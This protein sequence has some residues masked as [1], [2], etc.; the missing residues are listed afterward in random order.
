MKK[1]YLIT[2]ASGL[3]GQYLVPC[4]AQKGHDIV[5]IMNSHALSS[6]IANVEQLRADL[7]Q[8]ADVEN[9]LDQVAPEVIIHA[10]GMTN[11]DA[12]ERESQKAHLINATLPSWIAQWAQINNKAFVFISTDHI[13]DGK[14]PYFDEKISPAPLN[15]YAQTKVEAESLI[16]AHM[17]GALLLRTNF[18]GKGPHWRQSIT[19]WIWGNVGA[20]RSIPG[21]TDSYFSPI[22]GPELSR[23]MLM[24]IERGA[25]GIFH[26]G[27]RER[28]SKFDFAR[29]FTAM[30]GYDEALI[31]PALM[32]DAPLTAPRPMDMSM[33]VK[34][35]EAYLGMSMPTVRESIHSILGDY[36]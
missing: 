25:S 35:I 33:S 34:K 16:R 24:L 15:V 6:D 18:F 36:R 23:M 14:S 9:L 22:S 29:L 7:A 17:P 30:A 31:Y 21:F 13:T 1:K 3:L 10:A 26:V 8:K 20:G 32:Q 12:C 11:V 4:V 19:D 28:I 27:G 5:A 2:G